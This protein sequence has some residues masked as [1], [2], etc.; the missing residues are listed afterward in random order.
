MTIWAAI[1]GYEGTYEVSDEGQVRR[2]PGRYS[3]LGRILKLIQRNGYTVVNLSQGNAISSHYVH[4]LMA[5]A[6]DIPGEGPF[7]RHVDDNRDNNALSNLMRGT[8]LDNTRDAID[9]GRFVPMGY[10]VRDHC[11]HGHEFTPE[12]TIIRRA[13]DGRGCRACTRERSARYRERKR[14]N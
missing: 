8:P 6:F 2:L 7:V 14:A 4:R 1:P 3:P 10:P 11:K 5:D 13:G 9:N 12:N